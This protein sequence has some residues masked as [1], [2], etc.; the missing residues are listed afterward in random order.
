MTNMTSIL[1][2]AASTVEAPKA[3]PPGDYLFRVMSYTDKTQ[4]GKPLVSQNGNPKLDFTV[5][6]E[7][8][9]EVSPEALEGVTLPAKMYHRFTITENSLF[10]LVDFLTHCGVQKEG[11][12]VA[13]MIPQSLG[14]VFRG[15]V[16]HQA[17]N[18]PGD[19]RLYA[20]IA[21]TGVAG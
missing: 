14:T 8:P 20:N 11:Q 21:Q 2:R 18:K 3:L 9:L 12:S 5:Q 7:T 15:T 13:D 17:S 1:S 10:R 6:A 16:V 4:D 19:D